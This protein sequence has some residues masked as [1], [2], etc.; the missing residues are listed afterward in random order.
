M[1]YSLRSLLIVVT[2]AAVASALMARSR[3]CAEQVVV[4]RKRIPSEK[5]ME[6]FQALYLPH[7]PFVERYLARLRFRHETAAAYER[8]SRMPWLPLLL[9]ERPHEYPTEA[10]TDWESPEVIEQVRAIFEDTR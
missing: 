2:L 8:V 10:P 1:K 3:Y 9:P 7:P 5:E 6:E 4:L